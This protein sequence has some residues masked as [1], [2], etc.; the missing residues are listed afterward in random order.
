ML[1]TARGLPMWPRRRGGLTSRTGT[2]TGVNIWGVDGDG[3][4]REGAWVFDPLSSGCPHPSH[5]C[6][7]SD[8]SVAVKALLEAGHPEAVR[9]GGGWTTRR[10]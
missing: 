10:L 9:G 8:C 5:T 6:V 7:G 3:K 4:N 1:V 2:S